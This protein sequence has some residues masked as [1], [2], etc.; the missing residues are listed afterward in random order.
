MES[1]RSNHRQAREIGHETAAPDVVGGTSSLS[2]AQMSMVV[3]AA[4]ME[5]RT[6]ARNS[7]RLRLASEIGALQREDSQ[8]TID[9]EQGKNDGTKDIGD[10]T[11]S[12]NRILG[13]S[14][15]C[16]L[17]PLRLMDRRDE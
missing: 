3:T 14:V 10:E 9:L 16:R 4:Q 1:F 7:P 15:F 17:R 8:S 6:S 13:S 11:P 2:A 5:A 12:C